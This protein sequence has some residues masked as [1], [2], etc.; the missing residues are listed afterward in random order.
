M[1]YT[2]F[3]YLE[4]DIP[5]GASTYTVLRLARV[6]ALL[7]AN[8]SLPLLLVLSAD[9]AALARGALWGGD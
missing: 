5:C 4:T 8:D 3:L 2:L 6:A 9:S 1:V 7:S